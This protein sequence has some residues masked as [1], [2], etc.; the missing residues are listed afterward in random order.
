MLMSTVKKYPS[1]S[2]IEIWGGLECTINRVGDVFRDQL[3]D[4]GHYDRE[5][6]IG[7]FS[8]LGIKAI[9]YSGIVGTS[10]IRLY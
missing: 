10:S 1:S 4:N 6:D 7:H 5:G 2:K 8:K 9:R 3:T